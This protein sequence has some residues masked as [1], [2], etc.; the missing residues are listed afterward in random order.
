MRA[1]TYSECTHFSPHG[2]FRLLLFFLGLGGL[3]RS[4]RRGYGTAIT[5]EAQISLYRIEWKPDR[6]DQVRQF[7]RRLTILLLSAALAALVFL[8]VG[9]TMIRERLNEAIVDTLSTRFLRVVDGYF[10]PLFQFISSASLWVEIGAIDSLGD[11]AAYA[12][13]LFHSL[14]SMGSVSA[15][16]IADDA[17][18]ELV[19][20]LDDTLET[21]EWYETTVEHGDSLIARRRRADIEYLRLWDSPIATVEE[22]RSR[23]RFRISSPYTLL[24]KDVTGVTIEAEIGARS[25]DSTIHLW[26]DLPL[27]TMA[28]WLEPLEGVSDAAVFLL[29]PQGEYLIFSIDE[30]AGTAEPFDE[31]GFARPPIRFGDEADLLA[32]ALGERTDGVSALSRDVL[33]QYGGRTWRT[34]S[35]TLNVGRADILVGTVIPE[36]ALWI[37]RLYFPFQLV[38]ALVFGAVALL[39]ILLVRDF[40]TRIDQATDEEKLKA[41]IAGGESASLEL[42][43]S[44]RWDHREKRP[45]KDLELVIIKSIAAFN[46]HR[47]GTILIGVSDDGQIAGLDADY[48]CLKD[49]GKDYFELHLRNLISSHYGTA[50]AADR[51]RIRFPVIDGREI[52]RLDVRKGRVPLYTRIA[53]KGAPP[54]ERF[55]VRSGN[56]S[57]SIDTMSEVTEYVIKRFGGRLLR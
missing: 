48:G 50:F 46:N 43:A 40:M 35:R 53:A 49:E 9:S 57:R 21:Y 7:V 15:I 14:A 8:A 1:A 51:I 36:D 10:S 18:R 54:V 6:S 19:F 42:K 34:D 25:T 12:D 45:N 33:F 3:I 26:L 16:S 22:I 13:T 37:A 2:S 32:E 47:G 20:R 30:V 44:L 17:E 27:A 24:D 39:S 38:G 29:L 52:C 56:S 28:H 23:V 31:S 41:R 5:R 4:E 55:F 11:P